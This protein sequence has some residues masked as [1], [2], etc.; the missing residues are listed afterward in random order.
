ALRER[1]IGRVT[2]ALGKPLR[3]RD[4]RFTA[5]L[6][7]T[8]NAK[9]MRRVIRAAYLGEDPGDPSSLDDPATVEAVRE[10]V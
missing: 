10:A 7:K 1:L 9:V 2:T 6:P 4:V 3:P 8:R 5:A